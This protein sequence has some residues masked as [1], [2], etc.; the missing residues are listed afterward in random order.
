MED[1]S[2]V[3]EVGE[4]S[5]LCGQIGIAAI[6]G[7]SV[8]IGKSC[9]FSSRIDIRTG[10]SHSLVKKGTK[11]RI[12]PSASVTIGDH[13]WVGTGVT[14]LKGTSVAENCMVGAT[15]LLNGSYSN[16]NC[17]IAGIPAKE[18]KSEIDWLVERI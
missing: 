7:T 14:I 15:A 3:I 17:V 12:N 16:P 8:K 4:N 18:V 6:E 5:S 11:Q 13:V 1:D 2:N 9:L 10:D